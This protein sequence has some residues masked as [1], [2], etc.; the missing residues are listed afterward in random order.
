MVSL[1]MISFLFGAALG[2]LFKVV[3]LVPAMVI[4]ILLSLE[5]GVTHAQNARWIVLMAFSA[6]ACLQLGYFAGLG[7]RDFLAAARTR[8]ASCGVDQDYG[9]DSTTANCEE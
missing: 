5:A 1:S 6:S 9:S 7:I 4:V 2:Q 3:V 8:R